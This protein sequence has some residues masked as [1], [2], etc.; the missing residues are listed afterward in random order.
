MGL[1]PSR[2][3][4]LRFQSGIKSG[5]LGIIFRPQF[6]TEFSGSSIQNFMWRI[7]KQQCGSDCGG[8]S[9]TGW[10]T[11]LSLAS[12]RV[13][14]VIIPNTE[15]FQENDDDGTQAAVLRVQDILDIA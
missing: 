14:W 11:N 7:L 13:P 9:D 3:I 5:V 4:Q 10:D 6:L 15:D 2:N 1:Y 12:F 8:S